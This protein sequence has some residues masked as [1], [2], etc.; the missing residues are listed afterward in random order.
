MTRRKGTGQIRGKS[1][2]RR[3]RM[4]VANGTLRVRTMIVLSYPL[5]T[6]VAV[7]LRRPPVFDL[8]LLKP[9]FYLPAADLSD[10]CC[11]CPSPIAAES[12]RWIAVNPIQGRRLLKNTFRVGRATKRACD[13]FA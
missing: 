2:S 12:F 11:G 8:S 3:D 7:D 5:A 9:H 6:C 1:E 10:R 4:G 13:F